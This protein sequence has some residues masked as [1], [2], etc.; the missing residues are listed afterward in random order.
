[1]D[2][3][4]SMLVKICKKKCPLCYARRTI[5]NDES[6]RKE[7]E[8]ALKEMIAYYGNLYDDLRAKNASAEEIKKAWGNMRYCKDLYEMCRKCDRTVDQVNR[9][10]P[11]RI[12]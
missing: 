10:F 6:E 9:A 7:V 5:K 3:R 1:M 11:T 2:D 12:G 4:I 8:N